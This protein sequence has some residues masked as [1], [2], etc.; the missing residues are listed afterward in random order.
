[1][2]TP[3]GSSVVKPAAELGR[4]FICWCSLQLSPHGDLLLLCSFLEGNGFV[5][6]EEDSRVSKECWRGAQAADV[7]IL[8]KD[9]AEKKR[10]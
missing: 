4:E 3:R 10:S 8:G 1:M 6:K 5:S 2:V 7:K 9:D